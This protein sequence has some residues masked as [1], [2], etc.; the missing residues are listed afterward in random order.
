MIG[1]WKNRPLII[2]R[3]E[4]VKKGDFVILIKKGYVY[5]AAELIGIEKVGRR[6]FTAHLLFRDLNNK[7]TQCNYFNLIKTRK[8]TAFEFFI[9]R[10]IWNLIKP[11]KK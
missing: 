1:F 10:P 11:R 2:R 5:D 8:D 4:R 3:N 7:R 9:K 6:K